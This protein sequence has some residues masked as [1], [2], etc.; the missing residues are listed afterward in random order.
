MSMIFIKLMHIYFEEYDHI[1]TAIA[2]EKK[3]K[4]LLRLKKIGLIETFN[5]E[6]EDLCPDCKVLFPLCSLPTSHVI[7]NAASAE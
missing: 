4:G 6:W 5:K 1:E 2:R 3:I 7:L